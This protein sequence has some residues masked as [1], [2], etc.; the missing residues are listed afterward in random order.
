MSLNQKL[1][2][3]SFLEQQFSLSFHDEG[4]P[5]L[6]DPLFLRSCGCGQIDMARIIPYRGEQIIQVVEVKSYPFQ[7]SPFQ[8]GR[9]RR[10]AHLLSQILDLSITLEVGHIRDDLLQRV[11]SSINLKL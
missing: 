11:S 5:L 9:L 10:S 6:V 7:P 1:Q 3:G 4:I 8:L 2:K